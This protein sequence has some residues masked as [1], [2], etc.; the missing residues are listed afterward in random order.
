[1]PDELDRVA[2]WVEVLTG[3][4]L[5]VRQGSIH[6]LDNA[7]WLASRERLEKGAGP[8]IRDESPPGPSQGRSPRLAWVLAEARRKQALE[9]N[10]VAWSLATGSDAKSR[11]P[12]A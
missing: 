7:A 8:P 2:N 3:M 4:K 1:M 9:H 10:N 5:D 12:A 6:L 11:D